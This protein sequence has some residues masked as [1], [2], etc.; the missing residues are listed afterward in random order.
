MRRKMPGEVTGVSERQMRCWELTSEVQDRVDD[1]RVSAPAVEPVQPYI[2]LARQCCAGGREIAAIA[3]EKLSLELLDKQIL[4]HIAVKYGW[5]EEML[6]AVDERS[7]HWLVEAF[8]QVV[9]QHVISQSSYVCGMRR[10]VRVAARK[11]RCVIVGRGAHYLLPRHR[12]L[13]VWV[14]APLRSRVPRAMER[15][16]LSAPQAR[17]QIEKVD[18]DRR[19]FV[20][21]NFHRDLRDP[22]LYDVVVNTE[23]SSLQEAATLIASEYCRRFVSSAERLPK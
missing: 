10:I 12:G 22:L 19:R 16:G 14:I 21:R 15:W 3:A 1:E 13:V 9:N 5:S 11:T 23:Q 7:Q 2:A 18:S 6:D 20:Q 4:E 17:K 8:G